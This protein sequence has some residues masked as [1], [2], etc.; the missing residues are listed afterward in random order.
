MLDQRIARVHRLGQKARVQVILMVASDSYEERVLGLVGNKRDLFDNVVDP[1]AEKDVVG[2]S[3][4]LMETL[5]KDLAESEPAQTGTAEEESSAE[6]A[7]P[8]DGAGERSKPES[9]AP[10]N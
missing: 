10:L 8:I 4:R 9:S 2:V 7:V 1:D 6:V 5:V 3:Q